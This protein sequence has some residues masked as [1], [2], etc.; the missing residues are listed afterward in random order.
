MKNLMVLIN[1]SFP[2]LF[3]FAT[4]TGILIF[5]TTCSSSAKYNSTKM[6]ASLNQK[7]L[8]LEKEDPNIIIQFTGK[9]SVVIN[10]QM[11]KEIQDKGI[12]IE[13]I[14]SDIFTANGTV[15]S[16]KEI[17]LLDYIVYLELVKNLEIK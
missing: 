8:S 17:S 16:I 15:K 11:K 13:T 10:D 7:I 5:L 2:Y 3:A 14:V 12:K 9:T 6:D 1:Q 4:L